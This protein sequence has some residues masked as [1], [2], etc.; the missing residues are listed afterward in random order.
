MAA[1]HQG[2]A[3]ILTLLRDIAGVHDVGRLDAGQLRSVVELEARYEA[4]SAIPIR[5]IGVRMLSR[6]DACFV[7]L[8]DGS[9]RP[10]KVPTVYLV[11]EGAQEDSPHA[12]CV[13]G[14]WFRVVGEEVIAGAAA[15]DE[16]VI[17]LDTSFV[18]FPDRR[19]SSEVPCTFILPPIV[20]PELE[21]QTARLGLADIISIS[22]S[23]AADA[24]LRT[25]FGFPPTNALATLLIGCNQAP[26]AGD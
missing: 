15:S 26:R 23:L 8:K 6:R 4:S 9:F 2:E 11:E 7:L 17:P 1:G 21:R 16:A 18:I 10:P 25:A 19:S 12:L 13:D 14:A 24:Y 20:F 5:N 3:G 22:P